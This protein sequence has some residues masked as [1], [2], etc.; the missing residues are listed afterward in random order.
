ME[1]ENVLA[2]GIAERI[3]INNSFLKHEIKDGEKVIIEEELKDHQQAIELIL[4][5][6][7]SSKHGVLN[8]ITEINAVGHRVAH[9]GHKFSSS[10][11]I[12]EEVKEDIRELFI[13][14]PLH[15]PPNLQ[16]I[17]A[18]E[19]L[20]PDVPQV[21]VFDTAFHQTMPKYAYLYGL[22]YE[23][24]EKYKIRKYGF[25]GTSH[26]YVAQRAGELLGQSWDQLK[27]ISC[28]LGNGASITAIKDG[29][30]L[31]N[32]M[33]FT[34][35]EGLI[36]GTRS[37][38]IDPAIVSFLMIKENM[39]IKEIESL[40]NKKS[41]V[42]GISGISSD[43][44]DLEEASK[45]GNERAR[46]AIDMFVHDVKLHI[47]AYTA[48]LEGLDVLIFTAGLGENGIEV[49]K[50]ICIN[51]EAL[52]I[53][54]DETKNYVRCKEVEISKNGAKVKVLVIPTNEELMI[55]RDTKNLVVA[56]QL[57]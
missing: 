18:M 2:K 38:D 22:P 36:M 6:L 47:G 43:F 23:C 17:E 50:N 13:V 7:V 46:L 5:T 39:N 45:K 49:R 24:Y 55:A 42:L 1:A 20:L 30:S 11:I 51:M 29:K 57:T 33:G 53:T 25:H 31:E 54:I 4:Q 8:D 15:N 28:H 56:R 16:G 52:G 41:G 32:T 21:A 44:R 40:L 3:G 12:T 10:V 35:L 26:K 14:A 9:G 27:I 19:K 37:G 48:I 34:P